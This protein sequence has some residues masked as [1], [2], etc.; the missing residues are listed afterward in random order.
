VVN[1]FGCNVVQKITDKIFWKTFRQEQFIK[2]TLLSVLNMIQR[3]YDGTSSDP[4]SNVIKGTKH[5]TT[6]RRSLQ[7]QTPSTS[8]VKQLKLKEIAGIVIVPIWP[9]LT[10][11]KKTPVSHHLTPAAGCRDQFYKNVWP[12]VVVNV[13]S[14][15]VQSFDVIKFDVG[16]FDIQSLYWFN[17]TLPRTHISTEFKDLY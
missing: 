7:H 15:D 17:H 13:R 8:N 16:S 9:N 5:G 6:Q 11:D 3:Y 1:F 12:P 2:I 4:T 14:F 10:R